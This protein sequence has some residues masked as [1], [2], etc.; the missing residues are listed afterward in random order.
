MLG[1]LLAASFTFTATATGVEK[2]APVEF[3][4]VD[5]NSDRDYESLFILDRTQKEFRRDLEK[6]GLKPGKAVDNPKY[7]LWP[8][9]CPVKITPALEEFVNVKLPDGYQPSSPIF[10][11]GTDGTSG[12]AL[13]SL[14]ESAIV[15]NGVYP[16]GDVYNAY[17][18]K[19]PLKKGEKVQ[20]T[21]SWDE[22]QR[23]KSVTYDINLTNLTLVIS[24]LRRDSEY[25]ELDVTINLSRDLTVRQAQAIA[26][27]LQVID[28]VRIK[29]NGVRDGGIFFKAFLPQISWLTR[30]DR[31]VQPFEYTLGDSPDQDRLVFIEEDWTVEGDDPKLTPKTISFADAMKKDK[32]NTCFIFVDL[33]TKLS[34]IEDAMSKLKGSYV[35]YWYIYERK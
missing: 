17:T 3:Y 19:K 12:F 16:Q 34:R 8:V 29:M 26:N 23:P 28:T 5:K 30:K 32:T 1:L 22:S 21:I 6:A 15:F 11:G 7:I 24:L 18:V 25:G 35:T 14:S 2:G 4:W 20:F 33:D 31:L 10:T 9:G 27:A 13:Y